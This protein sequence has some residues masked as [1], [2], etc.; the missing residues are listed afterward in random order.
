MQAAL[1]KKIMTDF[2]PC[3]TVDAG[4]ISMPAQLVFIQFMP[5]NMLANS[6]SYTV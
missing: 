6:I 1:G 4:M 2:P 5:E 3:T